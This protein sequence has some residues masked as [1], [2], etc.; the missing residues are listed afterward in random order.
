MPLSPACRRSHAYFNNGRRFPP[1]TEII[2]VDDP[3]AAVSPNL[4]TVGKATP[5]AKPGRAN[6]DNGRHSLPP[7]ALIKRAG[8]RSRPIDDE[9]T[10]TQ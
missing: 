1:A 10:S 7:T 9:I 5:P 4:Y 8:K 2:G 6:N 3:S